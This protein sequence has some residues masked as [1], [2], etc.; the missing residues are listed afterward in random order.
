MTSIQ[1][2]LPAERSTPSPDAALFVLI[3][4]IADTWRRQLDDEALGAEACNLERQLITAKVETAKGLAAKIR[5]IIDAEFDPEDMPAIL[6]R[7]AEDA[8]CVG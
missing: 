3:E 5:A 4:Q 6:E 7:L 2:H 1:F 8:E